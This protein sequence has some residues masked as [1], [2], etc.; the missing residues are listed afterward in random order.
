MA[1]QGPQNRSALEEVWAAPL[2]LR[3]ALAHEQLAAL[4]A[5]F[6]DAACELN[7]SNAFELLVATVL[8]AQTTDARVN[9][10][11]PELFGRWPSVH[12]L[13]EASLEE[14]ED[15]LRPLGMHRRRASAVSG[16][17][18]QLV[19]NTGGDVPGTREELVA[20][21]GVGR[22]TANVVLGNWFGAEEITVDTHVER[23]TR[24]LGWADGATPLQ[25]E[26]QLWDLL[27]LAPWTRLCHQLI[28][29]GRQI[30]RARRP[31]C[32]ECPLQTLC[33]STL[34]GTFTPPWQQ[35]GSS[36]PPRSA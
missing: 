17:S 31:R 22:K 24:R 30:C 7:F 2:P 10:I 14:L 12:H 36:G 9:T 8:S 21:K 1:E 18:N 3:R 23:T 29:L 16:L 28:Q 4:Q 15:V 34:T 27:P 35:T 13:A 19:E 26:N 5:A 32:E 6:P 25:I 33:P 11:T 20:L